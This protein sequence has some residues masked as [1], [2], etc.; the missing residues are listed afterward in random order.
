MVKLV[1]SCGVPVSHKDAHGYTPIHECALYGTTNT[2]R[3]LIAKGADANSLTILGVSPL[4][5]A[6][7]RAHM[8][9]TRTLLK[10]GAD[11]NHHLELGTTSQVTMDLGDSS[12]TKNFCGCT[13]LLAALSDHHDTSLDMFRLLLKHGTKT[14]ILVCAA[15]P[16]RNN[17]R[18]FTGWKHLRLDSSTN[19]LT[20][21]SWSLQWYYPC[22][23]AAMYL[24]EASWYSK[25]TTDVF[26]TL[27]DASKNDLDGKIPTNILD[28]CMRE[29]C[30][31]GFPADW[32][33][34]YKDE[35][36][37]WRKPFQAIEAL[38]DLGANANTRGSYGVSPL[39]LVCCKDGDGC[40][41]NIDATESDRIIRKL[42]SLGA[43]INGQDDFNRTP[44]HYAVVH[45]PS[46]INTL[47][48]LG[49]DICAYDSGD[50]E[51]FTYA[52]GTQD[53]YRFRPKSMTV[54][55]SHCGGHYHPWRTLLIAACQAFSSKATAS[56]IELLDTMIETAKT[57]QYYDT[58]LYSY[59][60]GEQTVVHAACKSRSGGPI[61]AICERKQAWQAFRLQDR[62]GR[63]PLMLTVLKERDDLLEIVLH[64]IRSS[65]HEG[66]MDKIPSRNKQ[67]W[68]PEDDEALMASQLQY[69]TVEHDPR[70]DLFYL[71]HFN[72]KNGQIITRK[73]RLYRESELAKSAAVSPPTL[74]EAHAQCLNIRDLYGWTAL[75]YAARSGNTKM[76]RMLVEEPGLDAGPIKSDG[77]VPTPIELASKTSNTVC[78]Q[79]IRD[80]IQRQKK[81][82]TA[83]TKKQLSEKDR[84]RRNLEGARFPYILLFIQRVEVRIA[85]LI[86]ASI[87]LWAR[88]MSSDE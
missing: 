82:K 30:H 31:P 79:L 73:P 71:E 12:L 62:L 29:L 53:T 56:D 15:T 16:Q 81:W 67:Y 22:Q 87:W 1:L 77:M 4:H 37:S 10:Y 60:K 69:T 64:G 63:T 26:L 42:V 27:L 35:G 34:S 40:N 19:Y 65:V 5:M 88:Q 61:R 83:A 17:G 21:L 32:F 43:D 58:V 48:E 3:L 9:I 51:I 84:P 49:A 25:V 75:H 55:L 11:P 14:N 33:D 24:A 86:C 57:H 66:I 78:I 38:L 18:R 70:L 76:V 72:D 47:I 85:V 80:A 74:R 52:C 7:S 44:L 39:H 50:R 28:S 54:L 8:A 59:E 41:T 2:L 6:V 20:S 45:T 13:P 46:A 23:Y 36:I 68:S